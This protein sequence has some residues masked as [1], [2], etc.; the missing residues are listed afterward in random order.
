MSDDIVQ[1]RPCMD[2]DGEVA[3]CEEAEADY[4]GVYHGGPGDLQW[5]ADFDSYP[6]ARSFA[7]E[8]VRTHHC[9]LS[10]LVAYERSLT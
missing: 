1:I 9:P 7:I 2:M 10:D 4:F 6:D 5:I 3:Q 8:V